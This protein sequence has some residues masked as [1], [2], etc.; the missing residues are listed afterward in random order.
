MGG[1]MKVEIQIPQY[2][3]ERATTLQVES[4]T[5]QAAIVVVPSDDGAS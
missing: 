1:G 5:P 4:D 3:G 2:S